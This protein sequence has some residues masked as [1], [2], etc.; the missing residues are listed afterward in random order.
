VYKELGRLDEAEADYRC[1]LAVRPDD[2]GAL[3]NL[4]TVLR[5]RGDLEAAA[6]TFRT[7]VARQPA[8]APAWQN[9]GNVLGQCNQF[10]EALAAHR[11]AVRLAPQSPDCHRNLGAML[12]AVGQ[13]AE[14]T[15]VYQRW[16]E[17][18]P[19]DPRAQHFVAAC[20]GQA[21]PGRAS[22]DYVRAEFNGFAASFD[23]VLGRLEYRAPTLVADELGRLY[24][25]TPT[26][27][28]VLDAGCGT[29]LCGPLLRAA[30]KRLVGVDL[31]PAMIE[32]ARKRDLYDT[33]V[34]AELVSYLG[35]HPAAFDAIVSADTLV[36]FG[37]LDAAVRAA[38][39]ALRPAGVLIFTV[40][41]VAAA[42]APAGYRI[43]PHGRYSHTRE[44]LLQVLTEAGFAPP[45]ITA[46]TLRKEATEW[47]DGYLI[48]VRAPPGP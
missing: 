26:G 15:D 34:V 46:V 4:G 24:G 33:L 20:T 42:D 10:E 32:L 30:G 27:L 2:L 14:A 38:A 41:A 17:R 45:S 36:Y 28:D 23:E 16:R 9:L 37:A 19:D 44:Y 31:S 39:R 8:H 43:N 7:V 47:V 22:D 48:G 13:V 35:E 25:G 21:V 5:Q 11:E 3:N 6:A 12:I 18:F 29:G 1:V 40:E